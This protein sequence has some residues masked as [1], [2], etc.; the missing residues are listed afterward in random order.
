MAFTKKAKPADAVEEPEPEEEEPAPTAV[1][2]TLDEASAEAGGGDDADMVASLATEEAEG[3]GGAESLLDMF[4]SVG[5]EVI[6]RS[7]LTNLAG[8]VDMADLISELN[9]VA[10]ALGIVMSER[11]HHEELFEEGQIAA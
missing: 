2:T 6:D 1:E 3:G 10:A 7:M 11:T 4:T 5:I 8:E 9:I